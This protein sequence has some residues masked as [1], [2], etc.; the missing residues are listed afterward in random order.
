MTESFLPTSVAI[1]FEAKAAL[2]FMNGNFGCRRNYKSLWKL[3]NLAAYRHTAVS[4]ALGCSPPSF[5]SW[6]QY[7]FK[8]KT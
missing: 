7:S 8:S 4:I 6:M 1:Y 2:D 3:L 5:C